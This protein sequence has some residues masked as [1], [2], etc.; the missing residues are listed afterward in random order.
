MTPLAIKLTAAGIL[1]LALFC[2]HHLGDWPEMTYIW[3]NADV[4]V[5][6][7]GP[8]LD[9]WLHFLQLHCYGLLTRSA[10]KVWMN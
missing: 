10:A 1:L 5:S 9:L 2:K 8:A 4:T 6:Q 7:L 3:P